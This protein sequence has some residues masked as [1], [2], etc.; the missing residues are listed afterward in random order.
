M[1]SLARLLASH[2]YIPASLKSRFKSE[3]TCRFFQSLFALGFRSVKVS[4]GWRLCRRDT[5]ASSSLV[6]QFI[7]SFWPVYPFKTLCGCFI[8]TRGSVRS[9]A[10]FIIRRESPINTVRVFTFIFIRFRHRRDAKNKLLQLGR[11]KISE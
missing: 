8:K 3:K 2:E 1:V 4:N 11:A 9:K 6:E 5:E 7:T 10:Q